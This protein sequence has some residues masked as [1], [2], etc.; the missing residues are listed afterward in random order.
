MSDP[1][2]EEQRDLYEDEAIDNADWLSRPRD[3]R[4]FALETTLV[5]MTPAALHETP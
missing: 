2:F 4:T 5:D 3:R 1:T